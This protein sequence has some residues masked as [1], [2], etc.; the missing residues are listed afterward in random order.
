MKR[1][2]TLLLCATLP[3]AALLAADA[4]PNVES[5]LRDAVKNLTRQVQ[6]AQTDL[7]TAQAA[8]TQ[9]AD[10]F[11]SD[12]AKIAGLIKHSNEDKAAADKVAAELNAKLAQAAEEL[13]KVKAELETTKSARD[14]AS[15]LAA[16]KEAERAKLEEANNL[17]TRTA[18]DRETRNVALFKIA[19]EILDRYEQFSLGQSLA[20]K[21][22]FVG[23]TRTRLQNLV[24]DYKDKILNQRPQP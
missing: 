16:T 14:A 9:A 22:P 23:N 17:L 6:T 15:A 8:A 2:C 24:Q 21:E 13:E 10:Q 20:A 1:L 5:Q 7:A 3:G 4:G 12:E 18:A 19:N 11:K